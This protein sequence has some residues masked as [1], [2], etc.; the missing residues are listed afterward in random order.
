M[1]RLARRRFGLSLLVLA[2]PIA[3]ANAQSAESLFEEGVTA[4]RRGDSEA[5]AEAFKAALA[6][7]PSHE[8]AYRLWERAEQRVLLEMLVERGDLGALAE[9]FL[10][11]AKVGRREVLSDPGGARDVVARLFTGSERERNE[12]LL[13]LQSR[14]GE[15]A[16]PALVAPLG[17]ASDVDRRVRAIQALIRLGDA[18]VV[19][20]IQVL[21]SDDEL[22]RMNAATVLGTLRD[23]RAGA[24][25]AW[26]AQD[27]PSTAAR[28]V[29]AEA[30]G[31]LGDG[32]DG[33]GLGSRDPMAL[34]LG[35]AERWLAGDAGLNKPYG[36]GQVAW[37][38]QDGALHGAPIPK[39]R[40]L[41]TRPERGPVDGAL[42]FGPERQARVQ[43]RQLFI[44]FDLRGQ[45]GRLAQM[46]HP[47]TG[48]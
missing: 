22:T 4:Y 45:A 14:Y 23:P 19:P 20:L 2:L 26:L 21:H 34:S 24:A 32:L 11:L 9:R 8:D 47:R 30:L 35:L 37:H 40:L 25:L 10:Q 17:D 43:H 44:R 18:A 33:L 31:K 5:A 41:S 29:A 48:A 16:V 39:Q 3:G 27:D 46:I 42:R 13:A 1:L 36:A 15:W 7:N 6:S 12:A 28:D 38:W